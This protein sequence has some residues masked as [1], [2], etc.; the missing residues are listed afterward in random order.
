MGNQTTVTLAKAGHTGD[1]TNKYAVWDTTTPTPA[2]AVE[3][4]AGKAASLSTHPSTSTYGWTVGVF[5]QDANADG[6][7][8]VAVSNWLPGTANQTKYKLRLNN[9]VKTNQVNGELGLAKAAATTKW[10]G[11][12]LKTV[13][14]FKAAILVLD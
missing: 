5:A 2:V 6:T 1:V 4:N 12:K 13:K 10:L 9:D 3:S 8:A 14:R 11:W 7:C